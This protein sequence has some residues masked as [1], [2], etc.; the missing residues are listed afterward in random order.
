MFKLNLY[1][2][3]VIVTVLMAMF[4]VLSIIYIQ[5]SF[6]HKSKA[7]ISKQ[8]TN[9]LN[10]KIKAEADT[11]GQYIDFIQNKDEITKLFLEQD[12]K[13]LNNNIK[14]IYNSLNKN[15]DLT[16]MYFIKTD[17][18]VLLRV[19]DYQRDKDL[20]DRI[21]FKKAK[22]TKS[23]FY[24]LEFGPKKNYTLR[25]VKPWIVDGNIIGYI[26][27]GKEVDKI[28]SDISISLNSMIY[29]AVKKELYKD[30]SEFVKEK[31]LKI[32]QTKN[33]Y[34]VY[35]T[36]S[37]PK[38]MQYILNDTLVHEDISYAGLEYFTSKEKLLDV[39][40]EELG[41]FVFLTDVSLEHSVMYESIKTLSI[42]LL[43][44][45]LGMIFG[46]YYLIKNREKKIHSLT[47][48]LETQ[49]R[50]LSLFNVKLQNLFNLQKNLIVITDGKKIN[51]ANQAMFDFFNLKNLDDFLINYKCICERFIVNDN[52]FHLEK[53][54]DD[55]NWINEIKTLSG[56]QRIV[57]MLD[58]D[59]IS[60]A[61]S[62]SINEFEEGSFIVS[63]TDISTTM[64]EHSIL[65]RKASHDKL[66][67]ALNREFFDNNI[68]SILSDAKP[69]QLG[70]VLCDIDHFKEVNDTYGHNIGDIVLKEFTTVIH[71][72]IRDTDYLIRWG[73]EE[74]IILMRV[75]S[76]YSLEKATEHI[77]VCIESYKF[78]EVDKI[79]ASFGITLYIQDEDIL[80]TINRVDKGLYKVKN[81][82]RN[83]VQTI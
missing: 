3:L 9:N 16:H 6:I 25:V 14:K 19:H 66:T 62:V 74:F 71:D 56:E 52:F 29:I 82:G 36:F 39:S 17:G 73:G 68:R 78:Q 22:E 27:L 37:I 54:D 35:N 5:E 43:L 81:N 32:S 48:K 79:T 1:L 2:P 40:G 31:L 49:K 67:G 77:R 4:S 51:L 83:H 8:F 23:L 30:A 59:L 18:T 34:I 46:G 47:S 69:K 13:E 44:L 70:F 55:K 65:K 11:I 50:D 26:E 21:T 10:E 72:S 58:S 28:I 63:F 33:Y 41:Y 45:T 53:I 80:T 60:Y 61:F 20:I 7:S 64:I 15:V 24:G 38:E 75:N 76:I 12:K 42:L 57:A